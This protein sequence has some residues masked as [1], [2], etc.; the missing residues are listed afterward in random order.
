MAESSYKLRGSIEDKIRE[1][2]ATGGFKSR[3][4]AL[5]HLIETGY[6]HLAPDT[7]YCQRQHEDFLR[8]LPEEIADVYRLMWGCVVPVLKCHPIIH[9]DVHEE[10]MQDVKWVKAQLL[11]ALDRRF[12]RLRDDAR[13]ELARQAGVT[14]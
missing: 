11:Q 5:T 14:A 3:T 8:E 2:E 13:D 4:E 9:M 6:K 10:F 7:I 1:V 12:E